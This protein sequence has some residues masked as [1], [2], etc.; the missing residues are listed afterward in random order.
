MGFKVMTFVTE[1]FRYL[2]Y[3]WEEIIARRNFAL[4][5]SINTVVGHC[6]PLY[7]LYSPTVIDIENFQNKALYGKWSYPNHF[8]GVRP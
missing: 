5:R 2:G 7:T 3:C 8:Q 1:L 6:P 4:L